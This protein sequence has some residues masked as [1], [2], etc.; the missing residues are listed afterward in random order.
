MQSAS[1]QMALI[2]AHVWK[3]SQEMEQTVQ[4]KRAD[5]EI[6]ECSHNGAHLCYCCY[7]CLNNICY[8]LHHT[9]LLL[10]RY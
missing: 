4:V 1:I 5:T 7:Y 3:D 10:C 9:L 8:P 6:L 2:L